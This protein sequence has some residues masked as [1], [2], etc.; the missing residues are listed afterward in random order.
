M[1]NCTEKSLKEQFSKLAEAKVHFN[2]KASSW[3]A[4]A[5]KLNRPQPGPE[6]LLL[7]KQV[8]ELK[9]R[10][11]KLKE[12]KAELGI[13]ASSWKIL[14]EKL[15]KPDPEQEIAMLKEQVVLLKAEN[16]RLRE[17]GE[18]AFDEVGFWL[19]DRNFDRAKFEDFGVSEKA[20]EME[21]EAKKIYIELSQRYHPD[22]GGLDEQQANI[23]KLKKQMLAVVK[24]NGGMGL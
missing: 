1:T 11:S 3:K 20:T 14:A 4:L 13:K 9:E 7:E 19:L 15:N 16:K 18:N 21:S 2:I 22:N 10:F 24:L 17:A 6:E 5:Q 8:A 12:A 23:N